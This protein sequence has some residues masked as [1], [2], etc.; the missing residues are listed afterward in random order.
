MITHSRAVGPAPRNLVHHSDRGS[1][2]CGTRYQALLASHGILASMSR[3]GDCWDNAVTESFFSTLKQELLYPLGVQS[4]SETRSALFWYLEAHYN[5]R[6]RHST[7][8]SVSPVQFDA[9]YEQQ[10]HNAPS[11]T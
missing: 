5:R 10:L 8:C 2:Y 1:V 3:K 9:Q 6:R 11:D 7:L 4:E